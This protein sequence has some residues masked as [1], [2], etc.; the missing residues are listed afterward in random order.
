MSALYP[1]RARAG[2][3]SGRLELAKPGAPPQIIVRPT[4]GEDPVRITSDGTTGWLWLPAAC[5]SAKL[6]EVRLCA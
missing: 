2:R 5:E 3:C 4:T 1:L 6:M